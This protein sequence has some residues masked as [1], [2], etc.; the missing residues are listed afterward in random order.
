MFSIP[1]DIF[2]LIKYILFIEIC[3]ILLIL[4]YILC[5]KIWTNNNENNYHSHNDQNDDTIEKNYDTS[6]YEGD[7]TAEEDPDKCRLIGSIDD[8]GHCF[9]MKY[10]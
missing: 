7:I 6:F 2:L 3:I 10:H 8:D 1:T 9:R 5:K 4:L